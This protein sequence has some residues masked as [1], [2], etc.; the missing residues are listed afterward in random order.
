MDY[1]T[2]Y[3]KLI[4]RFESRMPPPTG[5]WHH[6]VPRSW[7]GSDHPS[8]LV[9]V[10]V[11]E[12]LHLHLVLA[13]IDPAQA[14]AVVML[15]N[16]LKLNSPKWVRKIINEQKSFNSQGYQRSK[17]QRINQLSLLRK[18]DCKARATLGPYSSCRV[19]WH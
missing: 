15:C 9:K 16:Q 13:R 18:E 6:I 2:H 10:T 11:R 1:P 14:F 12:H 7:G 17:V 5:H 19:R 4:T 3:L 8:N